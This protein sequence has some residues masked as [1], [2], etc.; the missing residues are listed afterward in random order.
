MKK[1]YNLEQGSMQWKFQQSRMKI[2]IIAGGF[3][4]G[5]TAAL[6]VKALRVAQTYPGA[7]I[8][9]ARSTYPKLN[10]T[11]RREFFRWCPTEWIK[12]RPTKDDNTCILKNGTYINFRYIAQ[13][14]KASEDGTTSS[15]LLSATYDFIG[16]DQA[17]DPEITHKDF[18]DL[19]GRLRGDTRCA[20]TSGNWPAS[21]PRQIVLTANPTRNWFY[22]KIIRPL[23]IYKHAK[24]KTDDLIVD[25]ETG[26]PII[27]LF[28]GATY[29][30]KANL[31]SDFIA[32]LESAYKGQMRD[33][34][35]LGLWAAYEGLVYPQFSY[36]THV[37]DYDAMKAY[38]AGISQLGFRPVILEGYDYGLAKPACYLYGFVDQY[39]NVHII[40]GFYKPETGIP[41]QSTLINMTRRKYID[42][43]YPDKAIIA[44][45]AIFIRHAQGGTSAQSVQG[46]SVAAMFVDDNNISMRRGT[47]NIINGITKVSAYLEVDSFHRNPYTRNFGAPRLYIAHTLEP[48]I[49]EFSDYYWKRDTSGEAED[50]PNGKN[51]HGMDTIK[52]M[53]SFRPTPAV[54]IPTL[55]SVIP[56]TW[57]EREAVVNNKAHRYG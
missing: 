10:D 49:D 19:L 11:L 28:E 44:D 37:V 41:Y 6:C 29:E 39:G 47:N 9:L 57:R 51:D 12:R 43:A 1:N 45:P 7:N 50:T 22:R 31:P 48:I 23:H 16:I 52:Y 8:L 14:G 33:R 5:K 15:N 25:V 26:E 18:V 36:E 53:L 21:G 38:F 55:H 13:Q 40:D 34:Y 35:L 54:A 46:K 27:D 32:T 4:N 30:N 56:M 42:Y 2:Q 24:V 3:G 17:E 20:D